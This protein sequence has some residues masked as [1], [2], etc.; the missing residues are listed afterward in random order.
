M[1]PVMPARY[2]HGVILQHGPE[3]VQVTIANEVSVS[4]GHAVP[5]S[6]VGIVGMTERAETLGGSLSTRPLGDTGFEV[7]AVVPYYRRSP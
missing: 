4:A 1:S 6:G 5:S 7:V 3:E 2:R